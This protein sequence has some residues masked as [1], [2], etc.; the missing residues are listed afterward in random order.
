[1]YDYNKICFIYCAN[2]E[3][4]LS[5]SLKALNTLNVPPGFTWEH[6]VIRN[7]PCI[8]Q[9]YNDGINSTN[10]KYKVYLHQDIVILNRNFLF[11]II[12]SFTKYPHL[13][14]IG[15]AGAKV[16]PPS[17]MWVESPTAYGKLYWGHDINSLELLSWNE[18]TTEIE[19]VQ[20]VDGIL[21]ATQ[22]DF[23]W[24]ADIFRG[25]HFYDI[26][27]SLEFAKAGLSLG[28]PKQITPWCWHIYHVMAGIGY[29]GE[30]QIFLKEYQQMI[31]KQ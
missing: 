7:A 8:T 30:R 28:I 17:G 27:Q 25:W 4:M 13:G 20:A 3:E 2:N 24:R 11:D 21:M 23:P 15:V 26:S 29:E 22:Y 31:S 18:V 5:Q 16:L 14:M 10:A 19:W 9:A 1:M 6:Q 12:N